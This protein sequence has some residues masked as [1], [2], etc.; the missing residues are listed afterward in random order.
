MLQIFFA[1]SFSFLTIFLF[2][3]IFLLE[4]V[5]LKWIVGEN[6]INMQQIYQKTRNA[7]SKC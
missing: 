5:V 1:F 6:G 3:L 7:V 2:F 4:F